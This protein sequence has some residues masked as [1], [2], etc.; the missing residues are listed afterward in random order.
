MLISDFKPDEIYYLAVF[1]HSSEDTPPS[2]LE[3][4]STSLA[5]NVQ[6]LIHFL[7]AIQI[8]RLP[9]KLFYASS[10][11]IFGR[12]KE[13]IQNE[14]TAYN[15]NSIYGISKFSGMQ[16][17]RY[18]REKY[19]LFASTGILYNH[20]S[21]YRQNKFLSK[22]IIEASLDIK[23]KEKNE[24]VLGN[25]DAK[26]DWGYAPDYVKAMQMIL[27][28]KNPDDFIVATGKTHSV[29]EFVEVAFKLQG[30]DWKNH[31][32]EDKSLV[33]RDLAVMAGD[34]TKLRTT[35]GWAPTVDFEGMIK[36]IGD[37]L[38]TKK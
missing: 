14:Q 18:Y 16:A 27:A 38:A 3:L 21:Q 28:S 36:A 13:S 23:R 9:I 33:K 37:A 24:L 5:V 17:C 31:V 8:S 34:A 32:S 15:P 35:T 1:H 22:K 19:G 10:S 30:L 11:H 26:A 2:D 6:Y 29:K 4:F 12:P 7:E 25:L 20:E